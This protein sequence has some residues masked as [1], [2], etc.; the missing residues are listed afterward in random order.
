MIAALSRLVAM[1]ALV[2]MP[3]GMGTAAAAAHAPQVS[4]E[5]GHCSGA[6][7]GAPDAPTMPAADC[8]V[9]CAAVQ[10]SV[11]AQ[12]PVQIIP[13][14]APPAAFVAA[15]SGIHLDIATPPP[16]RA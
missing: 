1:L 13:R 12:T 8:T 7:Q 3:I 15:I 11:P 5:A 9:G 4:A 6:E 14:Q 10:A 2:L 16:K